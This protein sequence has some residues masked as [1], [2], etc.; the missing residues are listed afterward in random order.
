MSNASKSSSREHQ[1]QLGGDAGD[2]GHAFACDELQRIVG[3]P[4]GEDERGATAHQVAGQLGHEP[5]VR[6]RGAGERAGA[7]APAVTDVGRGDERE[8]AVGVQRALREPGGAR[9][10]DDRH[11]PV[12]IGREVGDGRAL[13][14]AEEHVV[15]VDPGFH[16]DRRDRGGRREPGGREHDGGP[17]DVEDRGALRRGEL[18]VHA[19]RDGAELG[20]GEVCDQ[21]LGSRRQHERD[22]V[23]GADAPTGEPGRDAVGQSVDVAVAERP[24][25]RRD[26]GG[27][28]AESAGRLAGHSGEHGG[29]IAHHE[30]AQ[31]RR[32]RDA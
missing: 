13:L 8:L 25:G 1:R 24:A 6:E 15:G 21:V 9:R 19:G 23:T 5:Q 12:R 3:A 29:R 18:V 10:E 32:R 4:A 27:S 16:D 2:A 30:T 14:Q 28:I 7:A 11:R 26:V 22:D 31:S 20:R 17:G